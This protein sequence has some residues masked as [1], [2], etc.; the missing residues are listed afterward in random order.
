MSVR[1]KG[2]SYIINGHHRVV[3]AVL[4]GEGSVKGHLLSYT[5]N[6]DKH[7][8]KKIIKVDSILGITQYNLDT[9]TGTITKADDQRY[10]KDF[11]SFK[12]AGTKMV[13]LIS[14]LHTSRLS[15][16]GFV[17]EA[18]V[19]GVDEYAISEQLDNRICPVCQQM[20]GKV[21]SVAEAKRALD[22]ILNVENPDDLKTIQAWPTNTPDEVAKLKVM[23][24]EQM[25]AN[26]WHI[27]PFHPFCRGLLVHK[28][29]VPSIVNTPSYRQAMGIESHDFILDQDLA[30]RFGFTPEETMAWN[31]TVKEDP[32]MVM[33]YMSGK[34]KSA[35]GEA[36][37][38]GSIGLE[39]SDEFVKAYVQDALGD[40]EV[41]LDPATLTLVV[42]HMSSNP[43]LQLLRVYAVAEELGY[44]AVVV[45]TA[46]A[47]SLFD[48]KTLLTLA[49]LKSALQ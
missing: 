47:S 34:P 31:T 29:N 17:A 4:R 32:R 45:P 15:A 44:Q 42:T 25:Y 38:K 22:T 12:D 43:M 24:P 20:H 16:Y 41:T 14:Q 30:A 11:A 21:Y 13:Q 19:L 28:D 18:D 5:L 37:E 36:L 39:L 40:L 23:T 8:Y 27:P 7:R 6:L 10:L 2:E 48:G 49:E 35:L 3:A 46:V 26:N 1:Y 9:E 33:S